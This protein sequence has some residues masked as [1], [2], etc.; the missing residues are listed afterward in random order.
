MALEQFL[1]KPKAAVHDHHNLDAKAQAFNKGYDNIYGKVFAS[2]P[3]RPDTFQHRW[4]EIGQELA[5]EHQG[6]LR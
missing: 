1:Q 2:N 6:G 5:R 4:F 3:F